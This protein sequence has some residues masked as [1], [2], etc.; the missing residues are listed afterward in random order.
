MAA[1]LA[2]R[3]VYQIAAAG[4]GAFFLVGGILA[5]SIGFKGGL[6]RESRKDYGFRNLVEGSLDTHRPIFIVDDILSSGKSA[7]GVAGLLRQ[8]GFSPT[9][10]LTVFR[11]GWR[12]GDGR[13]RQAG[14]STESLATLQHVL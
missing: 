6:I 1:V 3:S 14:L 2:H 5:V 10:V 9:G 11:Y 8:E 7:L 4:F 12:Q 13:L